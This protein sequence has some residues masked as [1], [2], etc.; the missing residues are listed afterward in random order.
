MKTE[1]R[2]KKMMRRGLSTSMINI[3]KIKCKW[4]IKKTRSLRARTSKLLFNSKST[5]SSL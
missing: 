1:M 3:V 5:N 4:S 2:Y